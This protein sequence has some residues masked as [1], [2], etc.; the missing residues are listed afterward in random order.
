[1]RAR[2]YEPGSGRFISEDPAMDGFNWFS[3]CGNDPVN[4]ADRSGKERQLFGAAASIG[5]LAFMIAWSLVASGPIYDPVKKVEASMFLTVAMGAFM[6]ALGE[7]EGPLNKFEKTVSFFSFM[8]TPW[9]PQ[10]LTFVEA[11]LG[12]ITLL[13]RLPFNKVAGFAVVMYT[14]VIM[15]AVLSCYT[16]GNVND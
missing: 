3:Y 16:A 1:M 13:N 15:A 2:Y 5:V 14:V 6:F 12:N 11:T 9:T 8:A 7:T 10:I 4:F